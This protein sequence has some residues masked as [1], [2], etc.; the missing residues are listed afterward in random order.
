MLNEYDIKIIRK[1]SLM[2]F[3][4]RAQDL[5]YDKPATLSSVFGTHINRC[6]LFIE[7][8]FLM[9]ELQPVNHNG[10][11]KLIRRKKDHEIKNYQANYKKTY[12][13][14]SHNVKD[15]GDL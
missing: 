4:K 3:I 8:L 1:C 6:D 13:Q 9:H 11:V 2:N 14:N 12:L 15:F 10:H 7:F 5:V